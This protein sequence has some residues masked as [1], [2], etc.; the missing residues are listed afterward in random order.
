[1]RPDQ[2][3]VIS[4]LQAAL[5]PPVHTRPWGNSFVPAMENVLACAE[6]PAIENE[7]GSI[8]A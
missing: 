8:K 4:S 5:P 1:M 2:P 7:E 3:I 6:L